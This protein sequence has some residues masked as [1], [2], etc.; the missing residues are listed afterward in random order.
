MTDSERLVDELSRVLARHDPT[1]AEWR[2]ACEQVAD[3][4]L[5]HTATDDIAERVRVVV[6]RQVSVAFRQVAAGLRTK[7]GADADG[8]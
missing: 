8:R 6:D 4:Y 7:L 1:P 3:G 5:E 2:Q